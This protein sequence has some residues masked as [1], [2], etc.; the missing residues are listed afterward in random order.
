[1]NGLSFSTFSNENH[2][3][4]NDFLR[5]VPD[6]VHGSNPRQLVTGFQFL[7]DSLNFFHLGNDT[8]QPVLCLF[9]QISQVCPELAGQ[10]QVII[11]GW[12]ALLQLG[13]V[14][15]APYPNGAVFFR[16]L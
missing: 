4:P 7:C 16:Q 12:M 15:T 2:L 6:A 9:V 1:M 14:H 5:T 8:M 3:R 11:L 10:N 13:F